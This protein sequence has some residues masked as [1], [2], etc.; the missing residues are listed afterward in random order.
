MHLAF[1]TFFISSTHFIKTSKL[2]QDH[3][4]KTQDK[5]LCWITGTRRDTRADPLS[6]MTCGVDSDGGWADGC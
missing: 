5:H 6:T 1:F 3:S 2:L 4:D